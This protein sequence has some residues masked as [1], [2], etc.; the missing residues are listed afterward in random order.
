M[1][2]ENKD[3]NVTLIRKARRMF[4]FTSS[5]LIDNLFSASWHVFYNADHRKTAGNLAWFPFNLQTSNAEKM[6]TNFYLSVAIDTVSVMFLFF[7]FY[8]SVYLAFILL[9]NNF[10][11]SFLLCFPYFPILSLYLFHLLN[12]IKCSY[13]LILVW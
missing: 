6:S 5:D 10:F 12:L 3:R 9:A 2:L 8:L 1:C 11:S 7:N 4:C 13:S